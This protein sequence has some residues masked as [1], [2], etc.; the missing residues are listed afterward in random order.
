MKNKLIKSFSEYYGHYPDF[1]IK[2]PGRIN[3]IGEHTD[4]ND[5]F[6]LP[7]GIQSSVWLAV[8]K[9]NNKKVNCFSLDFS[10]LNSFSLCDINKEEN[11]WGEYPKGVA[12]A[13]MDS[14]YEL[15][16]W[17]GV[18]ISEIPIGAGLSSS[19]ALELTFARAFTEINNIDWDVKEMAL[20][21]QKA[22]NEWVGV[23][24]GIMDQLI[25]A[26]ANENSGLL[27]DCRSLD[28]K[29][30]PVPS[31]LSILIMDTSTRRGL[32]NTAYNQRRLSC[33]KAAD[34]LN[35]S[36][37]RDVS[38]DE[39]NNSENILDQVIYKRAYHVV[40]EIDR[41]LR[42]SEVMKNGD[43]EKLGDLFKKSHISLRDFY[44]VSNPELDLMVEIANNNSH[45][46]GARMTGAGFGGC[47]IAIVEE[48]YATKASAE[49]KREYDE[50]SKLNSN[51]FASK[52]SSGTHIIP[53]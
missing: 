28:Y 14:G 30:I 50:K 17:D 33:Q 24:C 36:A 15:N 53:I 9:R 3:L 19:A 4:Y 1:I 8:R 6:V 48:E 18:L 32:V 25:V 21:C 45:C 10:E 47:A 20:I 35:V 29:E 43:V 52:A 31:N 49:V 34:K 16:G 2:S 23:N 40:T 7:M 46:Y 13:L 12:W 38:I 51:I 11:T 27:L 22:E 39:L 42:A 44:E 26:A 37:L 41:T 5:G